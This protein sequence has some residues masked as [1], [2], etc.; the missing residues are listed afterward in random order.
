MFKR[1]RLR[2]LIP[3]PSGNEIVHD[4]TVDVGKAEVATLVAV[5]KL[6]V[7]DA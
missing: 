4:V 7:I 6:F 3:V 5:G 2:S 1:G